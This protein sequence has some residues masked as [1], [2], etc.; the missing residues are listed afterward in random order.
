MSGNAGMGKPDLI[1]RMCN[2]HLVEEYDPPWDDCWKQ[3]MIDKETGFLKSFKP[4]GEEYTRQ[5]DAWDR[6]LSSL[7]TS[8]LATSPLSRWTPSLS[9]STGWRTRTKLRWRWWATSVTW[10]ARGR[11]RLWRG[12]GQWVL[13]GRC[14]S[15]PRPARMW[16]GH[17]LMSSAA[18]SAKRSCWALAHSGEYLLT[19]NVVANKCHSTVSV[20][21]ELSIL[22][23]YFS[24]DPKTS[25][26]LC[27]SSQIESSPYDTKES[28]TALSSAIHLL[29]KCFSY[30]PRM[31]M[32]WS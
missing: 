31:H 9:S 10:T 25:S 8:S 5:L 15:R 29:R 21:Y 4:I 14:S 30:L 24:Q 17:L 32:L 11:C 18:F 20:T 16:R 6:R 27:H 28:W 3:V 26:C 7:S 2:N 13:C 1:V 22:H 12:R 23:S 19:S